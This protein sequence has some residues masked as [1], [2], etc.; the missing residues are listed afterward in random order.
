MRGAPALSCDE[1]LAVFTEMAP[2]EKVR[3][4]AGRPCQPDPRPVAESSL[5]LKFLALSEV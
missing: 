4:V 1:Q 2:V 5:N 3:L